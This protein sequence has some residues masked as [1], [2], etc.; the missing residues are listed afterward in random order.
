MRRRQDHGQAVGLRGD[1]RGQK[2]GGK[3]KLLVASR[4]RGGIGQDTKAGAR[5][6]F[7]AGAVGIAQHRRTAV[8]ANVKLLAGTDFL[9][10]PRADL[11]CFGEE[12][13]FAR[14][15]L[16]FLIIHERQTL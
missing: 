12:V 2:A 14:F 13:N 8:A 3:V 5:T 16:Q 7:K 1:L 10:T 4:G 11:A 6:E 15:L 9:A